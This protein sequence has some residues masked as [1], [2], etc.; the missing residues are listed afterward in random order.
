MKILFIENRYK[1]RLWEIIAREFEKNGHEIHFLIQNHSFKPNNGHIHVIPYPK[2]DNVKKE[3]T[4]EIKKIIES[5]RGLNYFGI[6]SDNFIFYYDSIID[7]K[8]GKL[9]PDVVFGESTLFHELLVI[10]ACKKRNILYLHPSTCRYPAGR[11][12]FY[13]YDTLEPFGFSNEKFTNEEA[14]KTI[15]AITE[16]KTL[17]DYMK[18]LKHQLSFKDVLKEKLTLSKAYFSGEKYNTP[19]PYRKKQI[20]KNAAKTIEKWESIAVDVN[21]L[22]SD[23]FHTLYAMQMQPEANIDVWGYPFNNQTKVIEDIISKLEKN[24]KLVIKP[25]PKSKYEINDELINVIN[26][27]K[28]KVLILKHSSKMDDLWPFINLVITVTGTVSLECVFSN[29]PIIVL[30]QGIQTS[31]STCFTKLDN[32]RQ[33]VHLIKNDKYPK[34]DDKE[35]IDFLNTIVETSFIGVNGDGLHNK[36]FLL[37]DENVACLNKAYKAILCF[38]N[39]VKC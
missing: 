16:R 12:S 36:T 33:I 3:Y 18:V 19:S 31:Q 23:E 32:Y 5:N 26:D 4:P 13:K 10:K 22:N 20:N 9:Q 28:D 6:K 34:L 29:K 37:D 24:E 2:K 17:P 25:N 8:I 7:D 38:V 39:T 15:N 1:T 14:L 27:N 21:A 11:F 35:K 30:G